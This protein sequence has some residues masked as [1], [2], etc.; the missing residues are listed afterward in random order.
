MP[1]HEIRPD[2]LAAG[3][4]AGFRAGNESEPPP[5]GVRTLTFAIIRPT[6]PPWIAAPASREGLADR[7]PRPRLPARRLYATHV[8]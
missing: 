7:T 3:Q 8:E 1:V 4:A 6:V 2:F 5:T